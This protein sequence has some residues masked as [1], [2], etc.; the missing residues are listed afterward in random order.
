MAPFFL[1]YGLIKGAYIGTEALATSVMHTV[2]LVGYGGYA[3]LSG[4]AILLGVTIGLVMI[5]GS[6]LG[7]RVLDRVPERLFPIIIEGVLILAGLQF[8]LSG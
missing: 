2:K 7:K 8:I 5:L 4:T 6:F 3:L 1:S